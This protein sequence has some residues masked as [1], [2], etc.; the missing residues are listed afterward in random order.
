MHKSPTRSQNEADNSGFV[1]RKTDSSQH[2]TTKYKCMIALA[3]MIA[4]YGGELLPLRN[5]WISPIQPLGDAEM[6]GSQTR[7]LNGVTRAK[8]RSGCRMSGIWLTWVH[9][10]AAQA[11]LDRCV[12][13]CVSGA[14]A[15]ITVIA[16]KEGDTGR[17]K[18][19]ISTT[20]HERLEERP[21]EDF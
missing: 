12:S 6:T 3:I 14:E 11:R 5:F 4:P 15:V 8:L 20:S 17:D 9:M 16:Y 2:A 18:S 10:H 19:Y 7:P 21:P 1:K 13:G